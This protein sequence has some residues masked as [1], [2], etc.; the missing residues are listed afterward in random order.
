MLVL[1]FA[2]REK[3][4]VVKHIGVLKIMNIISLLANFVKNQIK[5]KG[6]FSIITNKFCENCQSWDV[7]KIADILY[8]S[9]E[10]AKRNLDV[11]ITIDNCRNYIPVEDSQEGF[12][13]ADTGEVL[14]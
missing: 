13:I 5:S 4:Q 2:Q 11:D 7:C 9:D 14:N 6:V 3:N 1:P 8:K 10:D 12:I